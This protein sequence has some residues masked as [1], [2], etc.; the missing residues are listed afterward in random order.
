MVLLCVNTQ[1]HRARDASISVCKD[2]WT[3]IMFQR[4][5]DWLS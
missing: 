2:T 1:K 3:D 5:K 4:A